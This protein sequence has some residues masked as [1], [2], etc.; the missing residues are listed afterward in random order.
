M[1]NELFTCVDRPTILGTV[2]A[3]LLAVVKIFVCVEAAVYKRCRSY[4]HTDAVYIMK[5]AVAEE[6]TH[7]TDAEKMG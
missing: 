6:D 7:I 3:Q 4:E 2:L 5:L 1:D